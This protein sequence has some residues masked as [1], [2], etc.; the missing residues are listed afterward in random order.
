MPTPNA[1]KILKTKAYNKMRSDNNILINR[2]TP[3]LNNKKK[4]NINKIVFSITEI[5]FDFK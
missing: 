4:L 2:N 5:I 1:N 3:V